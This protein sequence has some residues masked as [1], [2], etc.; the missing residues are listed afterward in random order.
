MFV[1]ESM[2]DD[3][4]ALAGSKS[5]KAKPPCGHG[6]TPNTM[7]QFIDEYHKK[8]KK[9]EGIDDETEN[10]DKLKEEQMKKEQFEHNLKHKFLEKKSIQKC[11][12]KLEERFHRRVLS[13]LPIYQ[14]EQDESEVVK[15]RKNKI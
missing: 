10:Q 12:S 14:S 4:K 2:Y 5:V 13:G 15:H 11:Q 8:C 9:I 7:Q 1:V 3:L 6:H